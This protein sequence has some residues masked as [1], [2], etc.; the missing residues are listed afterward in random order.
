MTSTLL[1]HPPSGPQAEARARPG[2]LGRLGRLA[3]RRRGSVLLLWLGA[4]AGAVALSVTVGGDFEADYSTPGSDSRAAR[5]LLEQRFPAQSGDTVDVVVRAAEGATAPTVKAD[6][7][8]LLDRLTVL[9][10][11]QSAEDPYST[12]GAISADGRTLTSHLRLDVTNP[13]D[14]PM[15][16]SQKLLAAAEA[17]D[18]PGLEVALGGQTIQR[19]EQAE[20]GSEGVGL[21]AAAV[22]LLLMFGAVVA[23]GLPIAV[24]VAGLAV[25]T[26]LTGVVAAIV[27]VP[28]WAPVLATMIGLGIGIDYVLLMVTR[29][30]EWRAAGLDPEAATAAT[31][32]TAGRSVMV[33]GGTVVASMLG[34]FA[35]GLSF[36]RGAGLVAI[37]GVLVVMAAAVTL[38]PALLGY[39]GRHVDRLRVVPG[40][41]SVQVAAGGHVVPGRTWLSWG[42]SSSGTPSSPSSPA[43]RSCSRSRRPSSACASASPTP[44]TTGTARPRGRH[45]TCWPKASAAVRTGRCCWWPNW[46][47]AA[48]SPR[49]SP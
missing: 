40:R 38:F 44:A 13:V 2:P 42:A 27:N 17:A 22:I 41:R 37:V 48:T 36:M 31:L 20:I 46:A 24:A 43:W 47:E 25:S 9:P 23:A 14:M 30:R 49:S 29:F 18:R 15:T 35:M 7:K 33:A 32:D 28:D 11:V 21:A 5:Q 16:D 45:T 34:L 6:V 4:L 3:Y 1:S 8:A 26:L 19:A 39:V 12:P 10:H